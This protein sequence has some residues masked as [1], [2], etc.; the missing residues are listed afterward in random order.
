[1]TGKYIRGGITALGLAVGL[2]LAACAD[3]KPYPTYNNGVA[4]Y[5]APPSGTA[6]T[7]PSSGTTYYVPSAGTTYYAPQT[8]TTYY[9]P[10]AGTT[11]YTPSGATT[12]VAPPCVNCDYHDGQWHP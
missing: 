4:Y 9:V 6:Y 7:V 2:T 3:E 10:P 12:Y 5:Q 1:M 11:T 8:G